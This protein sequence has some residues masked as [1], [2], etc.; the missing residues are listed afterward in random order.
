MPQIVPYKLGQK[1]FH[2]LTT[3]PKSLITI[4]CAHHNDILDTDRELYLRS[5]REFLA[6]H[7]PPS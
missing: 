1:L 4:P 5:V 2:G 3:S 7:V 6:R